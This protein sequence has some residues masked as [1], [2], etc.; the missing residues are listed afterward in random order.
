[1]HFGHQPPRWLFLG[2]LLFALWLATR[3]PPQ[4]RGDGREYI[5]QTQALA[6]RGELRVEPAA[7]RAYWNQTNPF[8]VE[9]GA[10]RP[11]ARELCEAHQAGGGFGG[12]YPDRSGNY[13]YCHF[14]GY[15]LAVAPLYGLL[16][17]C[18]GGVEYQAFRWMNLFFLLGPFVLAWRLT[19]TWA[20]LAVSLVALAT[21]LPAYVSW[22]HPE[23][24]CF[25]LTTSSLL[26]AG[27]PRVHLL[28]AC[29]LAV[30]AAQNPP[31]LLCFPLHALVALQRRWPLTRRQLALWAVSYLPAVLLI[32]GALLWTRHHCGVF[33]IITGAGLARWDYASWA[34]VTAVFLGPLI[35]ALWYYPLCFLLLP[36][37]IGR[38]DWPMLIVALSAVLCATWLA[39]MTANFHSDQVGAWR[40][41]TWLLAPLWFL[42]LAP[43]APV[44]RNL[45][46]AGLVASLLLAG[47]HHHAGLTRNLARQEQRQTRAAAT[48]YR[49]LPLRDDPEV[50]A[51]HIMRRE[52]PV[53]SSFDAVYIWNLGPGDALWLVSRRWANLNPA[54]PEKIAPRAAWREHPIYGPYLLFRRDGA[55]HA[56][57]CDGPAYLADPAG[58]LLPP[59]PAR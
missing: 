54:W 46:L 33:N 9:L 47:W 15:S 20:V 39:T 52:L 40:Y 57:P 49:L 32:A 59:A 27:R 4:L 29:L 10:T 31:L 16:H 5:L 30:A 24:F 23:L 56:L 1:M 18:G 41:A 36:A 22:S 35:G 48:L 26:L 21:P 53:P 3:E 11:P 51:E 55:V 50:I 7:A 19:R 44:R 13:R 8:G 42:L 25:G 2:W 14:W 45:L 38:R 6:L 37:V 58:H 28:S 43:A 17:L 34:S 12:L